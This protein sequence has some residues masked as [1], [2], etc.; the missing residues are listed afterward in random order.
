MKSLRIV[1]GNDVGATRPIGASALYIANEPQVWL[2][3]YHRDG[4]TVV[5][6]SPGRPCVI[7]REP[8]AHIVIRDNISLS[9]RH[10]RFVLDDG[11]V[12]VEDLDSTNGTT[13]D[14]ARIEETDVLPGQV[15]RLGSVECVVYVRRPDGDM[16]RHLSGHHEMSRRLEEEVQAAHYFETD[17][18]FA[19][20]RVVEDNAKVPFLRWLETLDR[21]RP[22]DIVGYYG[23]NI[24]EIVFPRS[25]IEH[26]REQL[27]GWRKALEQSTPGRRVDFGVASYPAD[28]AD[29][30][31]LLS[32]ARTR[33]EARGVSDQPK[34][35]PPSVQFEGLVAESASMKEVLEGIERIAKAPLPIL[36]LGETGTGKEV[37]ANLIHRESGRSGN[38][39]RVN[40]GAIPATLIESTLFGHEKGAFTGADKAKAGVFEA[41]EGGTVLLDEI[42]ELP[43]MAQASLL[44]VLESRTVTR[45]GSTTERPVDL[46]LVAATHRNLE[47][48][49]E[50]GS[51]R[52]DLL[53][54]INTFVMKLPALRD[55]GEDVPHLAQHFLQLSADRFQSQV[56]EV[57]A[58][59]L[60]AMTRYH[61]PGNIR[62]LRNA[63]E[64]ACVVA[65]GDRIELRDLPET[66]L[67]SPSATAAVPPL[68][69]DQ[70]VI[71]LREVLR[72]QEIALIKRALEATGGN[73]T[74]AAQRLS[75][76][77]RTLSHRLKALGITARE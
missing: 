71:D 18:S 14:G 68:K 76:P 63:I 23:G 40:C 3:I 34:P 64:R 54:R 6:L 60:D 39:I 5:P 31:A 48:M 4:S 57:A 37:L 19:L 12:K 61:W 74:E 35:A 73:Q 45:V 75:I 28:A 41:A 8:P 21:L 10:A 30:R 15:V 55:R 17:V 27:E 25:D 59:A 26:A 29:G 13:L 58:D 46:R 77:R 20:V 38:F 65:D 43:A 36:I 62:E 42:G 9:R 66:L 32:K 7:G 56:R 1:A 69:V 67:G 24:V 44:R 72:T 49:C 70:D 16:P 50:E 51:F 22:V 33:L 11:I 52:S 2:G 47:A 53:F